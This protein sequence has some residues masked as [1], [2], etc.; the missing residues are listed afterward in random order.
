M[1]KVDRRVAKTQEAIKKA[2]LELMNE[3]KFETITIQ[4]IS[5]RANVNRS[6]IYLHY[7]DKYDLLDK[8]IDQHINKLTEMN[9]WACEEE[10]LDATLIFVKYFE[11]NSLFF[12]TMLAS[13][14]AAPSFRSKF[15]KYARDG[16]KEELKK[17]NVN[18][19]GLSE[20]I[21]VE[22]VSNA[23]VGVLE[24]WIKEG[25]TSSSQ[26]LAKDLG[27]LMERIL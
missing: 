27:I 6:T 15:I 5:D 19:E 26:S 23:Y 11:D 12:S 1:K 14:A 9:V 2:F 17:S 3:K 13:K 16:F 20:D 25:I 10:W 24:T 8:L 18:N 4:D 21:I 22:F 7:L